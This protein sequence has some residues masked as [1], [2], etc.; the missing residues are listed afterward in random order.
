L[1]K[2]PGQQ[3]AFD[4][5]PVPYTHKHCASVDIAAW[6]C[7]IE[8]VVVVVEVEVI[9]F[10]EEEISTTTAAKTTEG[11]SFRD[12]AMIVTALSNRIATFKM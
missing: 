5:Q 6:W 3:S 11:S 12:W 7:S 10:E 4:W 8:E 9:S 2:V 1:H